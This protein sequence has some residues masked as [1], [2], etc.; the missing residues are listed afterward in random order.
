LRAYHV[1][2]RPRQ[3]LRPWGGFDNWSREIPEPL[4]WLGV[5]DPCATRERVIANDP[6]RDL[7][8]SILSAWRDVFGHRAMSTA[9]VIR[10]ASPEL[11]QHLV[12]VAGDRNN[13]AQVDA[14]R[15]GTWCP[16]VEDRI[17]GDFQ[18][19]RDGS[20]RRATVWRVSCVSSVSSKPAAE[21]SETRT[22]S[23]EPVG[24][25]EESVSASPSFDQQKTNSPNSPDSPADEADEDGLEV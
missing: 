15:L 12:L 10:E 8:L 13:R 4:V 22:P 23:N 11:R 19:R 6:D 3:D 1:A 9:E 16:L 21:N 2:G 5:A 7:A 24:Q 20:V 17:F 18:L 25:A 14:W